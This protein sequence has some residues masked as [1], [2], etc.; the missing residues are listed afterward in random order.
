[1]VIMFHRQRCIILY[2]TEEG[3]TPPPSN[4]P[5]WRSKNAQSE[6]CWIIFICHCQQEYTVFGYFRHYW[7]DKR[8]VGK[9]N[10]S[11]R[12]KGS[13]IEH[14]WIPDTYVSNCRESNLRLKDSEAESSLT[15]SPDG[16]IFYSKGWVKYISRW[17]CILFLCSFE[18]TP[19]L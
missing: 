10:E 12:L 8:F 7:T 13:T 14:A 11:I 5:T 3:G 6:L 18:T 2:V 15:I 9:F 19:F 1:M 4:P 17:H 16:R